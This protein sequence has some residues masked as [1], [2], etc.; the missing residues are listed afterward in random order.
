[1]TGLRL[2]LAVSLILLI[3]TE[4][5]GARSG[6]GL[7]I[8]EAEYTFKTEEMFAGIFTIGFIGFFFN[9]LL[10]RIEKRLTRWKREIQ[11]ISF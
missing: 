1:M 10:V 7:M 4:M 3:V 11:S 2:G 9:E 8:I 6:L 5:I